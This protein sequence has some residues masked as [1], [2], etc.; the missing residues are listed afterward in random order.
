MRRLLAVAVTIG[1][2]GCVSAEKRAEIEVDL[3]KRLSP[4]CYTVDLF[5]PYRIEYPLPDVP[6]ESRKFLGVW[7]NGAWGDNWCHD[8]YVTQVHA[9]GTVDVIDAY[10]P[11]PNS[12]IDA[13]V[14]KR[15]GKIE[16][17]V[18]TFQSRFNSP[19]SYRLVGEF[20]VGERL[21]AFGKMEITMSRE[22]G[23][24]EVPI[25]PRN[26]RRS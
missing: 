23:L 16:N 19:V 1:L 10:G 11:K 22:F 24:A 12:T 9:D 2:A 21:D 20:L 18:L 8:L 25:P 6:A 3:S 5:D 15:K 26:P 4:G 7:K 13:H 14:F 17:G